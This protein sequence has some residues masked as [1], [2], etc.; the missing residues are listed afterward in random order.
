MS[1]PSLRLGEGLGKWVNQAV[2]GYNVSV[3]Q[4]VFEYSLYQTA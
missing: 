4:G 3:S 1:T 2:E